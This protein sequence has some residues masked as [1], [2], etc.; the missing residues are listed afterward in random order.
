MDIYRNIKTGNLYMIVSTCVVNATNEQD[1]QLM[2]LYRNYGGQD[3]TLYA[4]EAD[5]FY[6]KFVREDSLSI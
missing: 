3:A 5:E 1:G 4:R 2:I 6:K